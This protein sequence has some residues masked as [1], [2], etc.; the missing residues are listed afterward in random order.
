MSRE[1]LWAIAFTAAIGLGTIWFLLNFEQVPTREWVGMSG[2]ARRNPFLALERLAERMGM[3][4]HEIRSLAELGQLPPQGVLL[5]PQPRGELARR[6]RARL[7]D[8]AAK[9]GH[10]VIEAE[11]ARVPDP[12]LDALE[13]RRKAVRT[14]GPRKPVEIAW[15]GAE[16][17]LRVDLPAWQVLEAK[18]P[19]IAEGGRDGA[20][21]VQVAHG[22]GLITVIND[23]GFLQ[24]R[25]IGTHDHA[26]LGW[27]I[28][29]TG[30]PAT[31]LLVFNNPERLSLT[32]WLRAN[33]P[34]VLAAA[35]ALLALWLWRVAPRF[36]PIAPDVERTR[37]SL[38][39]HLRASGRF[40]WNAGRRTELAESAREVALRRVSRANPDFASLNASERAARLTNSFGLAP[41]DAKRLLAPQ[42]PRTIPDFVRGI[43]IL[44]I[45]HE[46]LARGRRTGPKETP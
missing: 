27:R 3:P 1:G 32:S 4:A 30:Q 37:R 34:A 17:P 11:P 39:D 2:E 31:V 13:I 35:I 41:E 26:E 5:L 6:E 8:W 33:A 12:L 16:R 44:Q 36:G 18:A 25:A 46:R 38:L 19:Q 23:F 7:L 42:S 22:K 10:L 15:P 45:I 40:L 28:V 29:G 9:G 43:R 14:S 24:N 21:L 20:V